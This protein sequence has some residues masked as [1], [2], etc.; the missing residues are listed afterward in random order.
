MQNL[1]LFFHFYVH[2]GVHNYSTSWE[3]ILER[4]W[5]NVSS[6][7]GL[8]QLQNPV[9]DDKKNFILK[10]KNTASFPYHTTSDLF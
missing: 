8:K 2:E 7:D 6:L 3:L 9:E 1:H 5:S 4:S 10:A